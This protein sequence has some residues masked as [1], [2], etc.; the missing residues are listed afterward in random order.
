M[1]QH[2]HDC[3]KCTFLGANGEFDLYTC[4]KQGYRTFIARFGSQGP[5]YASCPE[6]VSLNLSAPISED[7]LQ[8]LEASKRW[9]QQKAKE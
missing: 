9:N 3:D 1:P 6:F 4:T 5:E 8:C 2:L 7:L